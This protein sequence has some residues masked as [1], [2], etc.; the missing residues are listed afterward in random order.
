M[1]TA[2]DF[3]FIL[4]LKNAR[5]CVFRLL[6]LILYVMIVLLI[7]TLKFWRIAFAVVVNK[8]LHTI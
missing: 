6:N 7:K 1:E 2:A 3:I 8:K 4:I 5:K